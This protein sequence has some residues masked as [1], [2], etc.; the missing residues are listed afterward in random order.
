[1]KRDE[2][3]SEANE[4]LRAEALALAAAN[5]KLKQELAEQQRVVETLQSDVQGLCSLASISADWYWEQDADCRF[6]VFAAE[7][8][9]DKSD[10]ADPDLNSA[11]GKTRWELPGAFPLSMSWADHRALLDARQAFRDFEYIRVLGDGIAHYFSASG[12]PVFDK[13][14]QFTGYRGTTRDITAS[15]RTEDKER[16]AAQFLDDIV[17]NIPMAVHLKSVQDGFRVVAWNKAA[18]N[19]YGIQREEAMGRTIHDLW[20]KPDADRMHASDLELMA[21]GAMQEFPDLAAHARDRGRIRV[22]MRKLPLKDASGAVTHIL[23]TS[24]DITERLVAETRLRHSQARFR[25]LTQLSSDWYWELDDK[26][27]FT[28]LSGGATEQANV[29]VNDYLG[30]TRWEVDGNPRNRAA[31]MQHRAQLEKHETFRNFEYEHQHKDGRLLVFCISGEPVFDTQGVFSGY[32]GVGTDITERKQTEIALRTSEARFRAVVGALAEGVVL[33]DADGKIIDCNASAERIFGKSLAQIRGLTSA[34][35][36]WE[37]LRED[38]THMPEEEWPSVIAKQT[39]QAQNN[40]LVCYR[41]P[42]G[43]IMWGLVNVQPLFDG[44]TNVPTGFVTSVADIS[45]R[46]QAEIEIVRLNVDLESRVSRRTAQLEVANKE[47]EAF[48]YSVAHDLRTPLSTIDGFC[49]LLERALPPGSDERAQHFLSRIRSSVRRM[50]EL[51]DGLLSLARLSRTSLIWSPVDISAEADGILRR[52]TE[53]D[54]A[55]DAA[56]TV[57]PGLVA[58]AD[59]ALLVQVLENLIANAWKFSSKKPRTEISVGRQDGAGT[60]A[61]YFVRDNGAGFDMAYVDKLFGTFQRLHAPEEFTGSGI[62]LATVKRIITRHGGKIWAQ[63][64]VGEGS[65]FYF[66]LGGDQANVALG[67]EALEDLGMALAEPEPTLASP[68]SSDNDAFLLKDQQFSNAFE[69]AAIGMTLIGI[70]SRRLKVNNAFC[71]MLGYSE[72]EMLARSIYDLTHPDDIGWDLEQRKRALAGEIE[73][74]HTE[75]RYIHKLGHTVW[76]YMSC[77]LV[78]D[79]DRKP[80]H[81]IAQVQDITE[82]KQ[83]EQVLRE[84]EERF[85]ALTALSSDW[86]WEQDENF[87]FVEISGDAPHVSGITH[88]AYGKTPWELDHV[89]SD[90]D[91]AEHRAMLE[92][93]E[94]FRDF[95]A[96]RRDTLGRIRYLSISGV[97]IF[98]EMG[99]FTGYRGT[100][101]DTTEWRRITEALRTS[102]SQLREITDTVP[103]WITYVDVEQNLRFYNR[104]Y[105]EAFGLSHEELDG[106]PLREILGDEMYEIARPRIEEVLNGY[107]V[108]YERTQKT[109]RGDMREYVINYFPRYGDGDDEGK[110]VGFYSLANDITELK[111]IDR[112]KSEFVSTVSHEL[113]TPLT[114]IR[115]SLGLI[116][117]G[118]AGQLPE[119]VKTLVGIA[120][121]NC[122]RL[123]RLINDILDIEKIESGK[124]TLDLQTVELKPLLE[125]AVAAN[126]GYGAAKNV[127]LA[128][129]FDDDEQLQVRADSDRLTQVVTNLLSNAMKFSPNDGIVEIHVSRSVHQVRI[130]VRDRGPGIPEEF[131]KRIFQKFSQADSSDTRQKGGTGLGLNISRAIIERLGGSIGFDTRTGEGTTFF[132]ELPEWEEPPATVTSVMHTGLPRVLVCED[133]RDIA[134]LISMMLENAGFDPDTVHSAEEAMKRL[135]HERYAAITVDL[136]L[137]GQDGISLIRALRAQLPTRDVPVVVISASAAEGRVRFN[138]QS[139]TVSD[140]LEKPIDENL[141]VV[142]VRRAIA[143]AAESRPV[144]LHV[145]DD[146]DI[147]RIA[148]AIAQDF[149]TFVFAGTLAEGRARLAEQRFDLVLLDLTL[150]EGSGWD[151]LADIEALNRPPP[152]VIFSA[153]EVDRLQA[154]RADAVLIKA[155]TSNTELLETLQRVLAQGRFFPPSRI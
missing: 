70:D 59:R 45:K 83:T 49:V 134:R 31:W 76:G 14:Q 100:G 72:A 16:K 44:V 87:R 13:H 29:S 98:D 32:R 33:R 84:R 69:H 55:R 34:A 102:E 5:D 24:E 52:L 43:S 144:I 107:P 30:K 146:P 103:A 120:K 117:G 60:P 64:T 42:D 26:F 68:F 56:V 95:E 116:S 66:S 142:G 140:W 118:V 38:G 74:F 106:R 151:L 15:R 71:Q 1:V 101:R 85:R 109:A 112:M 78:R 153:L 127:K 65:T 139:L 41:R 94:V 108:V 9:S 47:I 125:Q 27:R 131:R 79:E 96:I 46:K 28:R 97:P 124:M 133:D 122:E 152:V 61:V 18:E 48:S 50:G 113:R 86:F 91:W 147:Q 110:V 75:K 35:L 81:F 22:H 37:R 155:K 129:L 104:A 128:L 62:G 150:P 7:K 36:D 67:D 154:A 63:S 11:L 23:V 149:A 136:K 143:G 39:G 12:V 54:P 137:P 115:G 135:E 126:E 99:R 111:R 6:I 20:P 4:R 58:R 25:S 40:S 51:T 148:A 19:L 123:I 90:R 53:A 105:Q 121:S 114:S 138:E 80:I 8:I 21:S 82:R 77:S 119:A 89:M 3:L 17:E 88:T 57:E 145:E 141:L 130:E 132:F 93:H 2:S 73:S 10:A 92:R